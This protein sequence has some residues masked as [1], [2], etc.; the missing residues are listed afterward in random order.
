MMGDRHHATKQNRFYP[1]M[2]NVLVN[3]KKNILQWRQN[4]SAFVVIRFTI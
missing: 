4:L 3:K 2:S 1:D